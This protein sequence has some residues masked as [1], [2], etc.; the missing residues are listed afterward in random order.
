MD[1]N[2]FE[3]NTDTNEFA[4]LLFSNNTLVKVNQNSEFRVDGFEMSLDN[5]NSYPSR[6]NVNTYNM[7]LALMEGE[8]YFVIFKNSKT[9]QLILQTPV[10]NLG[11]EVGKYYIQSSK[12][13]VL[14]YILEGT[15]DVYDNV[16]NK[17]ETIKSNNA[18]LINPPLVLSPKQREL[19]GDKANTSVKK[20]KEGQFKPFLDVVNEM[21]LVRDEVIF[22][23]VDNKI[24]GAKVK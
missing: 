20:P 8:A 16:T 9:D 5:T 18:V 21:E 14:V 12:K 2:T 13:S 11:L 19:F 7:N 15:L 1:I 22:I 24:V 17:K 10:S 3:I 4:I 6:I 23:S